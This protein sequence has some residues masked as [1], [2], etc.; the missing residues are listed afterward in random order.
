MFEVKFPTTEPILNF[1]NHVRESYEKEN[2]SKGFRLQIYT[3]K[4]ELDNVWWESRH[5]NYRKTWDTVAL[6]HDVRE[7]IRGDIETFLGS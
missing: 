1:L 4:V 6:D 7:M 5:A 2:D 3:S